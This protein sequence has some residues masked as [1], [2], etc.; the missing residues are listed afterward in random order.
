M[1]K[2]TIQ[3]SSRQNEIL[4]NLSVVQDRIIQATTTVKRSPEEIT[5]VAVS[6]T[7]P[8]SDNLILQQLGISDYAENRESEGAVKSAEFSLGNSAPARWHYQGKIQS[9]K[10]KSLANWAD[11]IHSLD[12]IRYVPLLAKAVPKGKTM[13]IFVQVSLDLQAGRGGAPPS[14]LAFLANS[15]R[16]MSNLRLRGIMAVAPVDEDPDLAFSRLAAI[17]ADFKAEFP[18]SPFLSAGMSGDFESAIIHGATHVRIG[19]SI[20]GSRG[21]QR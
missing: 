14:D 11:V 1:N 19:S 15:V 17:H 18:D 3:N 21:R 8:V 20:L 10:I 2:E 5:L 9:N 12:E 13:E 6:K 7:Y 16:S 4:E